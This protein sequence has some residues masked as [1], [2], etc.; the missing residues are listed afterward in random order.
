MP[1][2]RVDAARSRLAMRWSGILLLAAGCSS[3]AVRTPIR[4]IDAIIPHTPRTHAVL[5]NGG[6]RPDINYQSH[7]QH[8]Q[9]M[10]ALLE[11]KGVRREDITVFSGDGSDPA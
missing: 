3:H 7:L 11:A 5:I 6:G 9:G 4:A 10:V 2:A 8:V 1:N